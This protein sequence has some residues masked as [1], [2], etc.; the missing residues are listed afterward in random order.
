MR[1]K[2]TDK[3]LMGLKKTGVRFQV[4]DAETRGL[5]VVIFPSGVKSYFHVRKVQGRPE[6]RTLGPVGELDLDAARGVA[7]ELNGKLANWR[8][9]EFAGPSPL[10]TDRSKATLGEVLEEYITGKVKTKTDKTAKKETEI[11]SMISYIANLKGRTLAQITHDDVKAAHGRIAA[12]N[13]PAIA[14]RVAQAVKR[15][16]Y[17]AEE[18]QWFA[19]ANPARKIKCE[20]RSK[21][22]KTRHVQQSEMARYLRGLRDHEDK[23]FREI[24]LLGLC[25]GARPGDVMGMRSANVHLDQDVPTW[26]CPNE[27]M[28]K[29]YPVGLCTQAV[30]ILHGRQV[31]GEFVGGFVFP[32][33]GVKKHRHTVYEQWIKFVKAIGITGEQQLTEVGATRHTLAS[34]MADMGVSG[35]IIDAALGHKTV[36]VIG[37][38]ATVAPPPVC[39]AVQRA[40]DKMFAD[41]AEAG[42]GDGTARAQVSLKKGFDSCNVA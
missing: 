33:W 1:V 15:L 28:G 12:E 7:S 23:H 17:Y 8:A 35:L 39:E 41:E 36:G 27:K 2:F 22:I 40:V 18:L 4:M 3:Y 29:P 21:K 14:N 34:W 11:R 42:G 32:S 10:A 20:E 31:D 13:G 30:E 26:N 6:R 25:T 5:G 37:K 19:G 9:H 38:Y 24:V 16:F